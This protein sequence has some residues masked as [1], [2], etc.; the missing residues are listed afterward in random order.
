MTQGKGA[1]AP[2]PCILS[3]VD[4][5]VVA[6]NGGELD[7]LAAN[8]RPQRVLAIEVVG[9]KVFDAT[10]E[11]LNGGL[12]VGFDDNDLLGEGEDGD[13]GGEGDALLAHGA[14]LRR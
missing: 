9:V 1:E 2:F 7:V 3:N 6:D 14:Y 11:Q 10:T 12:V 4:V 13:E 5:E 8:L